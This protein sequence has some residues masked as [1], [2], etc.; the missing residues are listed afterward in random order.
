MK[1]HQQVEVQLFSSGILRI[2]LDFELD[3]LNFILPSDGGIFFF[4]MFG[5]YFSTA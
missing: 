3:L 1:M 4:I 5:F 2:T